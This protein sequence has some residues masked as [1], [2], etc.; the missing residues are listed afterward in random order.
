MHAA[1]AEK[2]ERLKRVLSA[3]EAAGERGCTSLELSISART[4]APG[5]C[6]SELRAQG[7]GVRCEQAVVEGKRVWRYWLEKGPMLHRDLFGNPL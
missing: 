7:I 6:V 5:T 1:S 4:V 2:S 3:L